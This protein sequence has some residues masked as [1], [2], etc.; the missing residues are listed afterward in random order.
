MKWLAPFL[1]YV[2]VAIGMFQLHSAWGG[3]L[4]FHLAIILSLLLARP[5]IPIKI[6]F[7]ANSI[8]WTLINIL[9]CGSSGITLYF[10]WDKFSIVDN[11]STR[12]EE[13]GLNQS[14]WIPFILYFTFVNPILEEYFWRAY[15]GSPTQDF[16]ISDFLYSGFHGLIL[17]NKVKPDVVLYCLAI[18]VLA[19]WFWRQVMRHDG[20]LLAPLLGHMAADLAI[21][22]AVYWRL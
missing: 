8:K 17:M 13:M 1:A 6:L 5:N 12:V 15:L 19:G 20:G 7:R 18:L 11:I 4:A 14:T 2:A 10:L 3:L 16:H 21:L 22:M 9:L